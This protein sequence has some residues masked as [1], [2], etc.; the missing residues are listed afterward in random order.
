MYTLLTLFIIWYIY[1]LYKVIRTKHIENIPFLY[2]MGALVGNMVVCVILI[3]IIG[4]YW[5]KY[6]P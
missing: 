6:L 2:F 4:Y 5:L 1:S 3:S